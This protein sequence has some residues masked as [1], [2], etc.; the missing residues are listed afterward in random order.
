MTPVRTVL[1]TLLALLAGCSTAVESPEI[2]MPAVPAS[3]STP[4]ADRAGADTAWW[5]DFEAPDLTA[6]VE[7]ALAHSPSLEAQQA[8]LDAALAQARIA[9]AALE[10]QVGVGVSGAR[11]KQNFIGLPVPGGDR[12]LSSTSTSLGLSLETSWEVDLWGRA[13]AGRRAAR[14]GAHAAELELAAARLSI[15]GQTAKAWTA[16]AAAGAQLDLAEGTAE[17]RT[18][19]RQRIERRFELGVVGP[20]EARLARGREQL[21]LANLAQTNAERD[22]AARQLE[23]LLRVY[24]GA[25]ITAAE[26]PEL[27]P[28]A[29]AALPAELVARRPDLQALEARLQAA[30]FSLLEARRSLYP[31]LTLSGSVGRTAS[32][33][34]DLLES[35]FDVWSLAG[36]LLRPLFQGGRLR[37]GVD[38]A[39]AQLDELVAL[40][41][42]ALLD[43]Y[44]E[45]ETMLAADAR[46]AE[47]EAA[48]ATAEQES[49]AAE[50]LARREYEQ[51]V[52]D[53]LTLLQSQR[54]H[55]EAASQRLALRA[56][57][58]T[59][60]IDLHLALG[61]G[62]EAVAALRGAEKTNA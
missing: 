52:S 4:L 33:V 5:L 53:Y 57:R 34:E 41:V 8:R 42:Q 20:L 7:R 10:P 21:A 29:S 32:E 51:G 56:Q 55:F 18:L 14:V 26:L 44:R 35:D 23:A 62:L 3:W 15:A 61:D 58:L 43:A 45:V 19:A 48:L 28:L 9:G 6:A 60:R 50:A 31:A 46:L 47:V 30:G 49:R 13:R 59:N 16:L 22:A 54:D 24:P 39:E 2:S 1:T 17:N 38:L 11:R 25:R 27:P 40:Y 37:A 36:G 12:V